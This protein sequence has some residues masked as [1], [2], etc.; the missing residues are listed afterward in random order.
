MAASTLTTP[1]ITLCS[2]CTAELDTTGTPHWCRTCRAKYQREYASLKKE[3]AESRGFA[4][5]VAAA[6]QYLADQFAKQ[7]S[8]SFTGYEISRLILQSKGPQSDQS[9]G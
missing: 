1:T 9:T 2:R 4:A 7:G 6:K 3:M 5:G 8:G